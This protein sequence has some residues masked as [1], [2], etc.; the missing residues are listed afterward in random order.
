CYEDIRAIGSEMLYTILHHAPSEIETAKR[1]DKCWRNDAETEGYL[2]AR[3][4]RY[5]QLD[6]INSP[7]E[8]VCRI[9]RAESVEASSS[10]CGR[11]GIL[12]R[13]RHDISEAPKHC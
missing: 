3:R 11:A 8:V 10:P 9:L 4:Y 12:H 7:C 2:L 6:A 13:N 5:R 1:I